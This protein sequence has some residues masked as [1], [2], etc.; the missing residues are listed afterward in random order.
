MLPLIFSYWL[1]IC[2]PTIKPFFTII[3]F[4]TYV[5]VPSPFSIVAVTLKSSVIPSSPSFDWYPPV[6]IF[7]SSLISLR[8]KVIFKLSKIFLKITN[9]FAASILDLATVLNLF[10]NLDNFFFL[11]LGLVC[12]CLTFNCPLGVKYKLPGNLFS[13]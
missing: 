6:C 7:P 1:I 5:T 10:N 2:W 4:W 13:K 11:A 8:L 9:C 12:T 3:L